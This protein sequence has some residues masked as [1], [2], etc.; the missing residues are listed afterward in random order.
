MHFQW[1]LN[2]ALA[3]VQQGSLLFDFQSPGG[4]LVAGEGVIQNGRWSTRSYAGDL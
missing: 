4:S 3:V 2:A 1:V